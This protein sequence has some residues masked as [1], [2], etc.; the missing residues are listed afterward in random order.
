MDLMYLLNMR[1]SIVMKCGTN[2]ASTDEVNASRTGVY[3]SG[4]N[5]TKKHR[6]TRPQSTASEKMLFIAL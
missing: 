3:A 4:F 5:K 6:Y 1:L 2:A